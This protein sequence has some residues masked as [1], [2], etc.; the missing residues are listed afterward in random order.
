MDGMRRH[1]G[2]DDALA[3]V[4]ARRGELV[5]YASLLVGE[6]WAAQDLVREA[7]IRTFSRPRAW[8]DAEVALVAVRGQ[9]MARFVRARRS[10]MIA[11]AAS[12]LRGV[13]GQ[14]PAATAAEGPASAITGALW[15]LDR[16]QRACVVLRDVDRKSTADIARTVGM[17]ADAVARALDQADTVLAAELARDLRGAP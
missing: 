15:M 6:R 9:I 17:G 16:R 11:R 8:H 2:W 12:R 13:D 3:G 5:G 14:P 4:V 1:G 10:P 7:I